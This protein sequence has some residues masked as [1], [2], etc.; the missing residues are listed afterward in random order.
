MAELIV[1]FDLSSG[2]ETLALAARLPGLRWAKVGP[3]LFNRKVL[4][5]A[6]IP[7][8]AAFACFSTFKWHDIPNI[9]WRAR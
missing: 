7:R 1:A 6:G 5:H 4:A 8:S 9:G 3:V 2:R